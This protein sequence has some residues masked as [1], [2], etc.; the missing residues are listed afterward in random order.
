MRKKLEYLRKKIAFTGSA[1][2]WERRYRKGRTSGSG[3]YGKYA[4]FKAQFLN[5]FVEE[6]AITSVIE[7]GCGDGNQ[8]SL[9]R[10]PRYI[11]LDVSKTVLDRCRKRFV[12]DE[13]KEF[14]LYDPH[15]L[16]GAPDK[17]VADAALSLDVIFH[18]V[19]DDVYKTYMQ[20]LFAAAQRFVVVLSSDR[21]DSE[22]DSVHVRH[23]KFTD[24]VAER[25]PSWTLISTTRNPYPENFADFYVYG[26]RSEVDS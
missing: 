12:E 23:H 19:E 22:T 20:R 14:H 26:R 1:D 16:A 5:T 3:S 6:N 8:L 21:E 7:F 2:Y 25:F 18:L 10:Y 24:L 13:T 17:F 9:V 11:G 15:L 4:E